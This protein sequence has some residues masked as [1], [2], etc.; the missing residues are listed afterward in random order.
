MID[1]D[2]KEPRTGDDRQVDTAINTLHIQHTH[3]LQTLPDKGKTRPH[4]SSSPFMKEGAADGAL[5]AFTHH[6]ATA[7]GPWLR[8]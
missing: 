5:D 7:H 3:F 4:Y 1:K 8:K 2:V 6:Y